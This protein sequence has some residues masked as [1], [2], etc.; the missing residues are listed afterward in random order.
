MSGFAA[1]NFASAVSGTTPVLTSYS[2]APMYQFTVD[3]AQMPA[4]WLRGSVTQ[5]FF[6]ADDNYG[7]TPTPLRGI[8]DNG[9]EQ[10]Y[11]PDNRLVSASTTPNDFIG[12][13]STG[14]VVTQPSNAPYLDFPA[15][16]DPIKGYPSAL[17]PSTVSGFK[18]TYGITPAASIHAGYYNAGDLGLGRDMYC[19]SPSG[20][21][22]C[23]VDNIARLSGG[24]PIFGDEYAVT[25]GQGGVV[26]TVV[27]VQPTGQFYVA[28][29]FG[30]YDANGN[31][32]D[33]IALDATG[34]HKAIPNNCM[35]CHGGSG[36]GVDAQFKPY[37]KKAYFLPFDQ[38][39]FLD[40][41][42]FTLGSQQ[43]QFRQL[44]EFVKGTAPPLGMSTIINGWY[45][46]K[47]N[48]VNQPFDGSFVPP[49]WKQTPGAARVY[50][51]V[52]APYCRTCHVSQEPASGGIDFLR[53]SDTENLRAL[54]LANVCNIHKMPHAQQTL[55]R[56]WKSGARAQLLG[57]YGRN[58]FTATC[59][60]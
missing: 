56:F 6:S 31:R 37:V 16:D 14:E 3:N 1:Y 17:I 51:D 43:E 60:R 25:H 40:R 57:H 23:L 53:A 29:V 44:N 52:I 19:R 11:W 39:A 49:L 9:S 34:K 28:P 22:V 35:T 50:S 18:S 15:H 36:M 20:F 55:I 58:D 8:N 54:I 41:G 45:Q 10:V 59:D 24:K 27:M 5:L 13:Y 48:T 30:A 7:Y 42:S 12:K 38:T 47:V 46:N 32:L 26:A 4:G 21:K 2:A 33:N